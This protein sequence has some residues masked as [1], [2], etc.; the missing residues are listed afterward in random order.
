[1]APGESAGC[2]VRRSP[3]RRRRRAPQEASVRSVDDRLPAA[4]VHARRRPRGR[5]GLRRAGSEQLRPRESAPAAL[6]VPPT[7]V[8]RGN[9]VG[10]VTTKPAALQAQAVVYLEDG[11]KEDAPAHLRA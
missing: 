4:S 7:A 2:R 11:P 8:P 3:P 6:P 1:M 9:I 5:V 10:A